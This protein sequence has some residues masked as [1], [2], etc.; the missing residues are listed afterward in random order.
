MTM[1]Q[2]LLT[3]DPRRLAAMRVLITSMEQG[4]RN[5]PGERCFY[6]GWDAPCIQLQFAAALRPLAG[7]DPSPY[8]D[9]AYWEREAASISGEAPADPRGRMIDLFAE[10]ERRALASQV[11]TELTDP[12]WAGDDDQ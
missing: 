5:P 11:P 6:D 12:S 7:M 8:V 10:A 4:H 2:R 1:D 3:D 9:P